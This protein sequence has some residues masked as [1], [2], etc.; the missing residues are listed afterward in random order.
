MWK[1]RLPD[2]GD[3][4]DQLDTALTLKS[5]EKVYDLSDAERAAIHSLYADYDQRLGEP[6]AAL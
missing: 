6:D 1:V 3:I 2:A 5:G 4:D